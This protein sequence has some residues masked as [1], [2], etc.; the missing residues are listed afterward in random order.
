[1]IA[2]FTK[3]SGEPG[4]GASRA[5]SLVVF[6]RSRTRGDVRPAAL[7]VPIEHKSAQPAAFAP[8]SYCGLSSALRESEIIECGAAEI[9]SRKLAERDHRGAIHR[10]HHE[11]SVTLHAGDGHAV[12]AA[13]LPGDVCRDWATGADFRC[14]RGESDVPRLVACP[15]SHLL[16]GVRDTTRLDVARIDTE[17]PAR[18]LHHERDRGAQPGSCARRSRPRAASRT[19]TPPASSSTSPGRTPSRNGP[20]RGTGRGALLAFKIHFGDRVPGTAN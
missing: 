6:P 2:S 20:E 4:A 17:P 11:Q 7:H 8:L 14:D 1:M 9:A 15:L 3:V 5:N 19:R 18:D 12:T 10:V 13:R 16:E